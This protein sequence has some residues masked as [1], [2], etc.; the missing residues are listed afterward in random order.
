MSL[1]IETFNQGN[2][3]AEY[4]WDKY[5][6]HYIVYVGK[7]INGVIQTLWSKRYDNVKSAKSSFKRQ[8][9]KIKEE[10]Y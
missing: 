6:P 7:K 5:A 2:I 4:E 9:K 3:Y 1:V 8:V 10:Q